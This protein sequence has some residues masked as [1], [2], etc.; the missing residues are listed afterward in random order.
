MVMDNTE[1]IKYD[2]NPK[3]A[4]KHIGNV[5]GDFI[6]VRG[7]VPGTYK[8]LIKLRTQIRNMPKKITKPNILEVV[9]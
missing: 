7:S 8:R 2:I 1:N 9:V 6:I 3:G 5:Y 4:F